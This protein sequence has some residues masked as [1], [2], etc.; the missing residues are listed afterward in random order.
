MISLSTST[1]SFQAIPLPWNHWKP[2]VPAGVAT[3]GPVNP[4]PSP[5]A[6]D[7]AAPDS[8]VLPSEEPTP[9]YDELALAF[10]GSGQESD[11]NSD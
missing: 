4:Q 9:I 5:K 11:Q 7:E 3:V 6:N 1:W 2:K 10:S 8:D